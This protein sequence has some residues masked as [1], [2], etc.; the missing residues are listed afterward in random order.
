MAT[1]FGEQRRSGLLGRALHGGPLDAG[2]LLPTLY[3]GICADYGSPVDSAELQKDVLPNWDGGA[4]GILPDQFDLRL[5][6]YGLAASVLDA[7]VAGSGAVSNDQSAAVFP[8][9]SAVA[10][11]PIASKPPAVSAAT[12]AVDKDAC[13]IAIATIRLWEPALA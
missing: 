1:Q 11:P 5:H 10:S 7:D 9:C 8:D 13:V 3:C 6:A 12:M 2:R 4:D